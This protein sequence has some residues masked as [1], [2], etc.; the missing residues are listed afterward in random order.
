MMRQF[1]CPNLGASVAPLLLLLLAGCA[2][3]APANVQERAANLLAL[4]DKLADPTVQVSPQ[5]VVE[6]Y[7][8]YVRLH[9]LQSK[10][11]QSFDDSAPGKEQE[12]SEYAQVGRLL[13]SDRVQIIAEDLFQVFDSYEPEQTIRMTDKLRAKIEKALERTFK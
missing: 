9:Q 3:A 5:Q 11:A 2:L 12:E 13:A 8:E 10:A 6:G 1:V 4:C 7:R